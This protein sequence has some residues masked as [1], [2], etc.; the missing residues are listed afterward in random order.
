MGS[1]CGVHRIRLVR[2]LAPV[3][4]GV[5]LSSFRVGDILRVDDG[6]AS[7]LVREGWAQLLPPDAEQ[8]KD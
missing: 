7:M 1:M 5:D 3:I 8:S 2:K 4:N 6:T